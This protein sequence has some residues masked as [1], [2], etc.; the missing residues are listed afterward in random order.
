MTNL[1]WMTQSSPPLTPN[2]SAPL[3][4]LPPTMRTSSKPFATRSRATSRSNACQGPF[5]NRRELRNVSMSL[6]R[7]GQEQLKRECRPD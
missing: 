3:S 7:V 1:H 4:P 2:T 6:C 5:S